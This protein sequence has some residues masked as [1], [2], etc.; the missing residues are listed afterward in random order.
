MR[1]WVHDALERSCVR[2]LTDAYVLRVQGYQRLPN[3]EI[4]NGE[5]IECV[6]DVVK[7]ERVFRL[8]KTEL[9]SDYLID[10]WWPQIF[11]FDFVYCV[12]KVNLFK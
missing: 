12:I 5:T 4:A 3:L 11:D 8:N 10:L 7:I 6:Q 1:Q 9:S 2:L